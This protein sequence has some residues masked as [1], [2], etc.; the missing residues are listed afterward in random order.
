MLKT[1]TQANALVSAMENFPG[2]AEA[3]WVRLCWKFM[4]TADLIVG[5]ISIPLVLCTGL[6]FVA[7]GSDSSILTVW[8]VQSIFTL[9]VACLC[10]IMLPRFFKR[11][12]GG[13]SFFLPSYQFSGDFKFYFGHQSLLQRPTFL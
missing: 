7:P 2:I 11:G 8:L 12:W 13:R 10:G 6:L 1:E 4:P 9:P 3:R 5:L